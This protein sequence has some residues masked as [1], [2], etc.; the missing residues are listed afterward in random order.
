MVHLQTALANAMAGIHR[1]HPE[2]NHK[3]VEALMKQQLTHSLDTE[4]GAI[5]PL[6]YGTT[7]DYLKHQT[8]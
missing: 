3:Q 6:D 1:A 8:Y 2:M 5:A 4:N 7:L